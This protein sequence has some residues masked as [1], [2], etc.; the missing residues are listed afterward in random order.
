MLFLE[1]G[2]R[3]TAVDVSQGQLTMLETK[4]ARYAGRLRLLR[5]EASA[6]V[7]TIKR[8]GGRHDIVVANSFL[9]H[10]PDYLG[11]IREA[12]GVL[13][14]HG[15]FFSFQDPLRYDSVALFTKVFSAVAY[16]P[17]RISEG[18][19]IGG[20][21]R[22]LRRRRGVYSDESPEDNFEYHVV[23]SGV[24]Q[25]AIRDLFGRLGLEC[26]IVRYFSTHGRI[27]QTVGT[28]LGVMN[29]FG[30]MAKRIDSV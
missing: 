16:L 9:H 6:A 15:Q 21:K 12:V 13:S 1:L 7:R 23:R 18:D 11:L 27:W 28:A 10:I 25:E 30:L 20:L 29:T 2:A 3:V 19:V 4:C 5:Q 24:D 26:E 22:R 17:W 8:E 14:P